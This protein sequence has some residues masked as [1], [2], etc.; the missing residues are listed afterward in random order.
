MNEQQIFTAKRVQSYL[1][2]HLSAILH[3]FALLARRLIYALQII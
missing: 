2:S 3:D 1:D